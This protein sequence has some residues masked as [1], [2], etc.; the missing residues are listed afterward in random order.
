MRHYFNILETAN[1]LTG[2][3]QNSFFFLI[4]EF[5]LLIQNQISRHGW[6]N[7]LVRLI[8]FAVQDEQRLIILTV[9]DEQLTA[10]D[11]R[12][13]VSQAY[14][15]IHAIE[16]H[17]GQEAHRARKENASVFK[18]KKKSPNLQGALRGRLLQTPP[19]YFTL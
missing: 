12:L 15:I 7:D 1:H 8:S 11:S 3:K 16:T 17:G 5:N 6:L 10:A 18:K 19:N 4:T 14:C 13:K 9:Q 2:N